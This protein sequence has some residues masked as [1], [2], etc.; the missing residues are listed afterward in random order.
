MTGAI[1][2]SKEV[3][4]PGGKVVVVSTKPEAWW[5][6]P[7]AS[8]FVSPV[9]LAPDPKNSRRTINQA[10]LVELKLSVRSSGIQQQIVVTPRAKAPWIILPPQD[11][12]KPFVIVSGWRRFLAASAEAIKAVP[13]TI[14]VYENSK[15]HR[16]AASLLN[17][18]RDDPSALDDAYDMLQLREEEG[19][20]YAELADH[21]GLGASYISL[22]MGLTKLDPNL[23]TV[24][25]E[26]DTGDRPLKISVGQVLGNIKVPKPEE[27]DDVMSAF[28]DILKDQAFLPS[29]EFDELGE[30]ERR[31][32]LQRMLF[33]VIQTRSLNAVRAIGFIKDRSLRLENSKTSANQPRTDRY[34]PSRRKDRLLTCLDAACEGEI[35]DWTITDWIKTFELSSYEDVD[36]VLQ[37][38]ITGKN[39]LQG[40]V[41]RLTKILNNKRPTNPEVAKLMTRKTAS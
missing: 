10:R 7:G 6:R 36:A 30:D 23:Q 15:Q 33:A 1:S 39:L 32:L 16:L 20:T 11:E 5:I 3:L 13:I 31:F 14:E 24:L 8:G 41:D 2:K 25:D 18:H 22:R 37:R 38:A 34:K 4:L 35:N 9:L 26:Y 19:W 28:S 40:V 29:Q 12:N 21:F 27:L 17:R